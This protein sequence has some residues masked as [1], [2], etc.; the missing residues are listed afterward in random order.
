VGRRGRL[1]GLLYATTGLVY[2]VDRLSKLWAEEV[3]VRRAP[4]EL[5]PGVLEL[6]YTTNSGGAFGL[7]G[8][9]PIVFAIATIVVAAIVVAASF[10]LGRGLVAVGLGLVLGGGLG[11]LTDRLVRGSGLDGRVVDFIDL[12]VWPIF[13]LADSAIVIGALLLLVASFRRERGS[14]MPVVRDPR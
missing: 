3:L 13:N 4:I 14:E 11:N 12:Q 8:D 9:A 1:V 7:G 2:L 10:R 6:N 5:I